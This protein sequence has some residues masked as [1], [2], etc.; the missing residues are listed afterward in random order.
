MNL[1]EQ[2]RLEDTWKALE[3]TLLE[4][5]SVVTRSKFANEQSELLYREIIDGNIT[6]CNETKIGF[7]NIKTFIFNGIRSATT[8]GEY[9]INYYIGNCLKTS[10]IIVD[11]FGGF[12]YNIG[13]EVVVF[14]RNDEIANGVLDIMDSF[15]EKKILRYKTNKKLLSNIDF[16]PSDF[17][18][19]ITIN[20]WDVIDHELDHVYMNIIKFG[21]E[22]KDSVKQQSLKWNEKHMELSAEITARYN[23]FKILINSGNVLDEFWPNT[24][25]GYENVINKYF[26]IFRDTEGETRKRLLKRLYQL[27]EELNKIQNKINDKKSRVSI[28]KAGK[29]K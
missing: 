20:H 4:R 1:K 8:M 11:D 28:N 5:A 9:R 24:N 23:F 22:D 18:L 21:G 27:R 17:L 3:V 16:S 12:A 2:K 25:T 26:P 7:G 29:T 14:L 15:P 19:D 13:K 10:G 6:L